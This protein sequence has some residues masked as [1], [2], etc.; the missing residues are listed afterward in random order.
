M[1]LKSQ[2]YLMFLKLSEFYFRFSTDVLVSWFPLF[3]TPLHTSIVVCTSQKWADFN[4]AGRPSLR[5]IF[6]Y[7]NC[8]T[9]LC[10]TGKKRCFEK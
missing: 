8:C 5:I 9:H 4:T 6:V 3:T 10:K 7:F 2:T 1:Q